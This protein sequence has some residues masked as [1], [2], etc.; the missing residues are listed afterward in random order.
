[1]VTTSSLA[2]KKQRGME[3]EKES[4]RKREMGQIGRREGKGRPS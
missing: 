1:M 2:E 3:R 4:W